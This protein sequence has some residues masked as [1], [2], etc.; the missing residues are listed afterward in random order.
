MYFHIHGVLVDTPALQVANNT[1]PARLGFNAIN[2]CFSNV[3]PALLWVLLRV[4]S[5]EYV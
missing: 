3:I 4:S 2:C 5:L 1:I